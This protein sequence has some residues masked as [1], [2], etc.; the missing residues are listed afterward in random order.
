M[1]IGLVKYQ[2]PDEFIKLNDSI[3]FQLPVDSIA[4]N[5]QQKIWER[6]L[7]KYVDQILI[8]DHLHDNM[9]D[10]IDKFKDIYQFDS[11]SMVIIVPIQIGYDRNPL[12][13]VKFYNIKTNANKS[14]N[15][16]SDSISPLLPTNFKEKSVRFY[17]KDKNMISV[18]KYY[19]DEFKDFILNT[20]KNIKQK[21]V[22][23]IWDICKIQ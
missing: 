4:F 5:I 7:Y 23:D 19:V 13:T 22:I 9:L 14:Y 2:F 18:G 20:R 11:H 12:E 1:L 10:I 3:I 8:P 17:I 16:G 21:I 15:L 6:D